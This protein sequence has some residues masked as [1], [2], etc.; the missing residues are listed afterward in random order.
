VPADPTEAV[1]LLRKS[2]DAGDPAGEFAL[3]VMYEKG[4]GVKQ[5]L[6]KLYGKYHLGGRKRDHRGT[7]GTR[8]NLR[9]GEGVNVNY[10]EAQLVS[11]CDRPG[12][13]PFPQRDWERSYSKVR[14][15]GGICMSGQIVDL[16]RR[17][18]G[19][20]RAIRSRAIVCDRYRR[21]S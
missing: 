13:T 2:A 11:P 14:D 3:G 4:R 10:G 7:S 1:R 6:K 8:P 18:R 15:S 16:G 12:V 19:C 21:Q 20:V 5:T 17:P 9:L